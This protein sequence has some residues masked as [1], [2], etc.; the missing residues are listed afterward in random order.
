VPKLDKTIVEVHKNNL[1]VD[2]GCYTQTRTINE[3]KGINVKTKKSSVI[4]QAIT[5]DKHIILTFIFFI[6]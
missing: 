3:K 2:Q 1:R 4:R 6:I 5:D